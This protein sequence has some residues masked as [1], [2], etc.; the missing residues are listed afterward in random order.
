QSFRNPVQTDL[1][2]KQLGGQRTAYNS[3]EVGLS[4]MRKLF[5]EGRLKVSRSMATF[6]REKRTY[7]YV[8]P[9]E[10]IDKDNHVID[11]SRYAIMSLMGGI[12]IPF[13]MAANADEPQ[14]RGAS[15]TNLTF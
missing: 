6:L 10:P 5:Y 2:F 8:K 4:N 3:I 15:T 11:A 1:E 13:E 14:F 9:F 7:F 12:G